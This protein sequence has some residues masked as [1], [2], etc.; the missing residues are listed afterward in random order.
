MAQVIFMNVAISIPTP[1][2]AH[3]TLFHHYPPMHPTITI[4]AHTSP[5]MFATIFGTKPQELVIKHNV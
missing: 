3:V 2:C 4:D 5:L 1:H